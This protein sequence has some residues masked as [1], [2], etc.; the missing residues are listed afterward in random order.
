MSPMR[1]SFAAAA[2][3]LGAAIVAATAGPARGGAVVATQRVPI[4]GS[5]FL[6]VL[7]DGSR[8]HV[9]PPP[10]VRQAYAPFLARDRVQYHGGLVIDQSTPYNI[11]W[12]PTGAYMSPKYRPTIAEFDNDIGNT[13]MYEILT[14]YYDS[15]GKPL[16]ASTFGGEWIDTS[17]YAKPMNDKA[18]RNEVIK[19]IVTNHWPAGGIAPIFFV[20]TASKAPVGFAACAYHG[21]FLYAGRQVV[22]SIVPYQRDYGPHGCGTPSNVF[23][24]D[25]DADLTIDTMWHEFAES[26]SDPVNGWYSN[27][28]GAEIG[29]ICQTAYGPLRSDGSDVTLNNGGRFVTQELWSNKD[30]HCRQTE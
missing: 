4:A 22:Y 29:D 5:P 24:N 27:A 30:A 25:Q 6:H 21:N 3:A 1:S 7:P 8:I 15:N 26:V 13:L 19:A 12:Q 10:A 2:L 16:N 11:Y 9:Y 18:V 23:P 20:F 14:Q 28:T 17:P